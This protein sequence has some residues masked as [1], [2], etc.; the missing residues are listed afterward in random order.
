MIHLA[1][2]HKLTLEFVALSDEL[3]ARRKAAERVAQKRRA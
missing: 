2:S 3:A 1:P